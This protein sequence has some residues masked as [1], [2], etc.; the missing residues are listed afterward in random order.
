MGLDATADQLRLLPSAHDVLR[1]ESGNAIMELR[2]LL[3]EEQQRAKFTSVGSK[4][5]DVHFVNAK[6]YEGG[7]VSGAKSEKS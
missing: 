2:R 6:T 3:A 7:K 5:T 4:D 1:Q